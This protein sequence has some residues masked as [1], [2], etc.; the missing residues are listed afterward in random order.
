MYVLLHKTCVGI[1]L[2][3]IGEKCILPFTHLAAR[4]IKQ[5]NSL[6]EC[7]STFFGRRKKSYCKLR[8][9]RKEKKRKKV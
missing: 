6:H 9:I 1:K 4:G 5:S 8:S 2:Y 7:I 3:L